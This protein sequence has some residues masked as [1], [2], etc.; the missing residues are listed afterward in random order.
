MAILAFVAFFAA[1]ALAQGIEI[2]IVHVFSIK[3]R[4]LAFVLGYIL[5]IP[6]YALAAFLLGGLPHYII[7]IIGGGL[8]YFGLG[9]SLWLMNRNKKQP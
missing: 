4:V 8:G 2:W 9:I 7:V 6:T 5:C 3:H 1:G